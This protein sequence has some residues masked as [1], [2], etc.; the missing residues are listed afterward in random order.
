LG[1]LLK[2][3]KKSKLKQILKN[4]KVL[5]NL[6]FNVYQLLIPGHEFFRFKP[7][8]AFKK[9]FWYF[10]TLLDFN[11]L[12]HNYKFKT[13]MLHP[14]L[15]DNT[16]ITPI[17][18]IYF[19]QDLWFASHIFHR[20][21]KIH[22]DIGSSIKTMSILAQFTKIVFVDIRPPN[23]DV[24]NMEFIKGDITN[25]LFAN[26]SINSLSSICVIEHIGLGRYGDKLDQ[27]GSEKAIMELKRVLAPK[28]FLYISIPVD[29]EN[30]IYFNAHRA[31]TRDYIL[32]L[33]DGF[34]IIEEKYTYGYN[35]VDR[36]EKEKGFGTG[37]YIFRKRRDL[38]A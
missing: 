34:E 31:F 33:F 23:I 28:G 16:V 10:S 36:Y 13:L 37:L 17:E 14:C 19:Y 6:F 9:Y 4:N 27:F 38:N 22:F 8:L 12:K 3:L 29:S 5:Y 26:N 24:P 20:K 2:K 25:L 35:L 32:E 15:F 7:F 1:F 18:P 30:K 21:P 11:R